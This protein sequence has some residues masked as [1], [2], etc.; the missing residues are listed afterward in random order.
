[1]DINLPK[2]PEIFPQRRL[3][4]DPPPRRRPSTSG[5]GVSMQED[6]D[7]QRLL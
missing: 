5:G 4:L 6:G 2:A 7:T 3:P 1:M